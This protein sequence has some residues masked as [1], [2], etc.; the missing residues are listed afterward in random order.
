MN[1]KS[2]EVIIVLYKYKEDIKITISVNNNQDLEQNFSHFT[3]QKHNNIILIKTIPTKIHQILKD[4]NS[5]FN[6]FFNI[7]NKIQIFPQLET[8]PDLFSLRMLYNFAYIFHFS[9]MKMQLILKNNNVKLT[10]VQVQPLKQIT[11]TN[12]ILVTNNI[13]NNF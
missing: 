2:K 9:K 11:V 8:H 6:R 3:P 5:N 7:N 10:V 4:S 1:K 13:D 12:V